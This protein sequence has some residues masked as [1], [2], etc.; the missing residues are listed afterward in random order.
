MRVRVFEESP[1]RAHRKYEF[2]TSM[3]FDFADSTDKID[4]VGPTQV[5]RQFSHEETRVKQVEIVRDMC[6]H[7]FSMSLVERQNCIGLLTKRRRAT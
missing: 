2:I 7:P 5:S 1:L 4:G 6:T 3:W